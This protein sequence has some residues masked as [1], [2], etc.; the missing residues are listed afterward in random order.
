MI[1]ATLHTESSEQTHMLLAGAQ[2]GRGRGV[3]IPCVPGTCMVMLRGKAASDLDMM[4]IAG[5]V[6]CDARHHS[7]ACRE[8]LA[9]HSSTVFSATYVVP[10]S[11]WSSSAPAAWVAV[12]ARS[13]MVA[14]IAA[15]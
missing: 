6:V 4:H 12:E 3:A 7:Y 9:A 15:P 11:H 8:G 14:R 13:H 10:H 2:G 5:L 1:G